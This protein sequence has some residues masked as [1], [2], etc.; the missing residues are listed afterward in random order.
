MLS[1]TL[2][3]PPPI[4]R[5]RIPPKPA[6]VSLKLSP[7]IA[8][9][10]HSLVPTNTPLPIEKDPGVLCVSGSGNNGNLSISIGYI[11]FFHE[12]IIAQIFDILRQFSLE[13]GCATCLKRHL[14]LIK[15]FGLMSLLH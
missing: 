15:P 2:R 3:E 12:A 4:I 14:R 5:A 8:H 6:C 11:I 13:C 1:P 9:G 7:G 10:A